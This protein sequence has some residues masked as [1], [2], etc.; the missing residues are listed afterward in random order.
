MAAGQDPLVLAAPWLCRVFE[1]WAGRGSR[2]ASEQRDRART[3]KLETGGVKKGK[4]LSKKKRRHMRAERGEGETKKTIN[5]QNGSKQHRM[6][7]S[8]K[9]SNKIMNT[10]VVD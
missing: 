4:K 10:H 3:K 1:I 6:H 9:L 8:G 5:E 2:R 7:T